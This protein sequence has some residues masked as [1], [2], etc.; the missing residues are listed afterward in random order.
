MDYAN[1]T[2]VEFIVDPR[3]LFHVWLIC[4]YLHLSWSSDCHGSVQI[5][6]LTTLCHDDIA[7]IDDTA[8]PGRINEHALNREPVPLREFWDY[9]PSWFCLIGV[10]ASDSKSRCTYQ[11]CGYANWRTNLVSFIYYLGVPNSIQVTKDII[12]HFPFLTHFFLNYWQ[13]LASLHSI[14]EGQWCCCD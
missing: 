6:S 12:L 1:T 3:V 8:C 2:N 4:S 5:G 11:L 7:F 9:I 13:V 14:W 10:N